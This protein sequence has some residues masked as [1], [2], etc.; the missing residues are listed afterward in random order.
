[1]DAPMTNIALRQHALAQNQRLEEIW[2]DRRDSARIKSAIVDAYAEFEYSLKSGSRFDAP[3]L[4]ILGKSGSGKTASV[5]RALIGLGLFE[6]VTGDPHRPFLECALSGKASLRDL[7][8]AVLQAYGWTG[9]TGSAKTL[10]SKACD[11]MAE[12]ETR[13][14]ILDEIQHV[15]AAGPQDRKD[16]QAYLKSIV[17][18]GGHRFMPILV[19][20]PEFEE[21]LNSDTQ[22]DR[23]YIKIKMRSLDPSVDL[24]VGMQILET[25]CHTVDVTM[26]DSVMTEE[27]ASRLMHAGMYSFGIVSLWCRRGLFRAISSGSNELQIQHFQD[28]YVAREDCV[29]ALNPFI[30]V[31][32][33]SIK[34]DQ[35]TD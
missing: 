14:L 7:A 29:P 5:I 10:W 35:L 24:A 18:P 22:L 21:V 3:A 1:M 28:A 27:F 20:M 25:Y 13:V 33:H 2:F 12:L 16:L 8:Q 15:R 9:S 19:G 17:Q 34:E 26:H 6:T 30:A 4:A 31:N 23:R 32:F 11:Y